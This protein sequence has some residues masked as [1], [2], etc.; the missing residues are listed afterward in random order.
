MMGASSTHTSF[1]AVPLVNGWTNPIVSSSSSSSSSNNNDDPVHDNHNNP[2]NNNNNNNDNTDGLEYIS[3]E[4][5]SKVRPILSIS[6]ALRWGRGEAR[7][8]EATVI[9]FAK[10]RSIRCY[11]F[12]FGSPMEVRLR[13]DAIRCGFFWRLVRTKPRPLFH[14]NPRSG[15]K[16]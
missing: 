3:W 14:G 12:E 6:V 1:E 2:N 5:E 9:L 7:R 15:S 4:N 10:V 16:N 13:F 8:G 11:D